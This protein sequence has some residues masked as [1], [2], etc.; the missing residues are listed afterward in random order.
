MWQR[1]NY[2]GIGV[3]TF[4]TF[5]SLLSWSLCWEKRS[6]MCGSLPK[7]QSRLL[8]SYFRIRIRMSFIG[9]VYV[10]TYEEFV[11]VTKIHSA[12]EWQHQDRTQTAKEQYT[13]IQISNV[14]NSKN[15]M[16][17]RQSCVYR[18]DMCKFEMKKKKKKKKILYM[19]VWW[20]NSVVCSTLMSSVHEMDC[21]GEETVPV[22]GRSGAQSSVASTRRQQFPSGRRFLLHC[23]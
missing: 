5:L 11:I 8:S 14:Q 12:T 20:I 21:L 1:S 23:F 16:Q 19:Y 10:Y 2:F 22:S 6:E 4:L 13:N 18:S 7:F 15:T 17:Y 9:Q 3:F